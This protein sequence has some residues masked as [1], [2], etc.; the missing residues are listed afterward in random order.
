[1]ENYQLRSTYPCVVKWQGGE[2][3]L[4]EGQALE[5]EKAERL[6]IYPAT[7]R[8]DDISFVLD[9]ACP[10]ARV[11]T[12]KV[13][14]QTIFYLAS[15]KIDETIV[16]EKIEVSGRQ[17]LM[18]IGTDNL[19]IV[20]DNVTKIYEIQH[21]KKYEVLAVDD[22]A[23]L[24]ITALNEMQLVVFNVK[25]FDCEIITADKIE[26]VGGEIMALLGGREEKYLINSGKFS[27]V[28]AF[29]FSSKNPAVTGMMF[30]Q[31]LKM[32]HYSEACNFVDSLLS[33]SSDKLKAYFGEITDF[34]PLDENRYLLIKKSGHDVV[35]L[36]LKNSLICNIEMLD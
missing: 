29:D 10:G 15:N 8:R 27:Q 32:H 16:E 3:F 5:F 21:P 14:E 34:F 9:M 25:T 17:V 6:F 24:K 28:R 35:K 1:M 30:L 33:P 36:D 7:G 19:K 4:E 31:N 12:F 22:F 13:D 20:L 2:E 26:I 23:L 18:Q 11:Q